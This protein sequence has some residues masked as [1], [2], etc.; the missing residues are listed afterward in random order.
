MKYHR[1]ISVSIFV[2]MMLVFS[3]S[4]GK[5]QGYKRGFEKG[6]T[7]AF[8]EGHVAGWEEAVVQLR[9]QEGRLPVDW[10]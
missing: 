1:P 8:A 2:L 7:D 4:L 5:N 3:F 9:W 10:Q 6:D